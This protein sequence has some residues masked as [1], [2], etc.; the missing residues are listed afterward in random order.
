[1]N[2]HLR[3]ACLMALIAAA[4]LAVAVGCSRKPP[5][6]IV[7]V[8][9]DTVRD[10]YTG[11]GAKRPGVTPNLDGL[12]RQGTN[13]THA[14]ATAPWTT[15]SHVSMFTGLLPSEHG[16]TSKNHKFSPD[17]V[18]MAEVLADAGYETAAFYSNPWLTDWVTGM[19]RGFEL[20]SV[21]GP[22]DLELLDILTWREQGG[23]GTVENLS[24]WLSERDGGRPFLAFVN[25][26]E[27]HLPYAPP[28]E[29]RESHPSDLPRDDAITS[30]WAHEFNARLHPS[31]DVDWERV[32]YLYSGDVAT[33]DELLGR[34]LALLDAR[35][36]ADDTVVIVTSDHGENLGDHGLIDHQFGV[37]ETLL[38]VPLVIRAPGRLSPGEREDPVMLTDLF[39]TVAELA[40]ATVEE[41]PTHSRSLLGDAAPA[42]R[43]LIA[44]Y[45]GAYTPLIEYMAGLNPALDLGLLRPAY[46]TVRVGSMRLTV[47]SDGSVVL[48]DVAA[49]PGQSNDV[50]STAP[51][52]VES[53]MRHL[54]LVTER[55]ESNPEVDERMEE[56]LRALG[57]IL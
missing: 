18:T 47:G 25:L 50:A 20:Q 26:L 39:A 41:T 17:P 15:P 9:L 24:R 29:Y 1:M 10:D 35:G 45:A 2:R 16:C 7:I 33:S 27:A 55:D 14:W 3:I 53:L 19:L 56:W 23:P 36:L 38:A 48:H 28:P 31:D 34:I 54:P 43:P 42:D 13:F 12:A 32:S 5:P 49:D 57:Y 6:N 30:L 52:T 37:F 8:V 51:E 44:E 40:D 21:S 22:Q 46:G 11:A 4:V